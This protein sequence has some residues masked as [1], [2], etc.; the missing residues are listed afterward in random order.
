MTT[1][2]K[3]KK[4]NEARERLKLL[5]QEVADLVEEGQFETINDAIMETMYKTAV[6]REFKTYRAWKQDGMQ[7]AKGEKAFL[8]WAKPKQVE[9]PAESTEAKSDEDKYKFFPIAYLF[10][11]AQV[12]PIENNT[13][14]PE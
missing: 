14:N 12:H 11:N 4:I 7:V 8:L 13:L 2:T 6:H 10:S 9:K 3:E 1:Q 5:S